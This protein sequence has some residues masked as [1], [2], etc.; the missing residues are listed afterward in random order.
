[1]ALQQH[2][3]HFVLLPLMAQGHLIP[4]IDMARLFAERGVIVTVITTPLNALRFKTI[5]D[6]AVESGL[7]IRLLQLRLPSVEAG[8]P[9]GCE[10][11]DCLP[12]R[13]MMTNFFTATAMLQ[14]PLEQ[15]LGELQPVPSCIISAMAF[16]WAAETARKFQIPRLVFHG[17]CCFSL[18]CCHNILQYKVAESITSESEA[19]VVPGLP[20]RIEITKS[21]LPGNLPQSSGD[22]KNIRDQVNEAELTAYGVVV[23]SFEELEPKYVEEYLKAKSGKVWCI[24]PVSQC[25]KEILDKAER[26]K[27]ASI[28]EKQC[29][30]W[31]D[32]K[33]PAS[34]VYVCLGSL[35]RLTN[36]EM[37]ELGLGLE[38]S[39]HPFVWVIRGGERYPEVEKW[40]ADEEFEERTKDRGLVIKGWAPQSNSS[41]RN[42]LHKFWELESA[43]LDDVP[44]SKLEGGENIGR[45]EKAVNRVMDGGDVGEE[46]RRRVREL[47]ERARKAMEEGGS[48]YF[49][50]T[51]FIQDIMQHQA[52][53][54]L[55][56]YVTTT[57]DEIFF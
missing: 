14:E 26:G 44:G 39:G 42:W 28:D 23:N 35:C 37:I 11:V 5:I 25:N 27:K 6:R 34:V 12:S 49:N 40:L 2:Q 13:E 51:L 3:L 52:S 38:A 19:F 54:E 46:T 16:P 47:G 56:I 9:E 18:L 1:M 10:N 29:L 45:V 53:K 41:M 4:M 8:L 7:P 32:A 36:S 43:G 20:D 31:L 30:N 15:L 24:G 50:M 33:E 22:L 48:S 17:T 57:K 55:P 21:M